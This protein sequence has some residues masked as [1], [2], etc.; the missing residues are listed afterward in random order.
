M[1]TQQV[2]A[3]QPKQYIPGT[4]LHSTAVVICAWHTTAV[5]R[6]LDCTKQHHTANVFVG[7]F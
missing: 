1:A 7:K 6:G 3:I 2:A 5:Y 4:V